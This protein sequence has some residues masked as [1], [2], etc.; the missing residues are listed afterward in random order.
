[1]IFAQPNSKFNL[2][3][4]DGDYE[5]YDDDEA[6]EEE[7]EGEEVTSELAKGDS[8]WNPCSSSSGS[9]SNVRD[10]VGLTEC[11]LTATLIQVQIRSCFVWLLLNLK[12]FAVKIRC[13]DLTVCPV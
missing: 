11:D 3:V 9:A 8:D 12:F 1:M 10:E 7:E 2:Q 13:F 6:V 4:G 5:D